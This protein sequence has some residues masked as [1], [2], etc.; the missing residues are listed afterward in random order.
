MRT[1]TTQ[2]ADARNFLNKIWNMARFVLMQLGDERPCLPETVTGLEDRYVLSRLAATVA[3][4]REHLET[5]NFNLAAEAIYDFTWHDVCDWYLEMAKVRLQNGSDDEAKGVLYHVLKE[6]VLLLHPFVPF[7]TEEIWQVLGEDPSSVSVAPFP[8]PRGGDR[9][10]AAEAAITALQE[11]VTGVRAI[12]SDLNVPQNAKVT[13]KL[14]SSSAPVINALRLDVE[15]LKALSGAAVWEFGSDLT[16]TPGSAR[17]VLSF[18]ELFV[19]LADLIDV[20]A[21]RARLEK[22]LGEVSVDLSQG[23]AKLANEQFLSRAPADVVEKERRKRDEFAQK[24]ERLEANLASL[25]A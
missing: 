1:P 6:I 2:L 19:P 20:P 3:T 5:Y 8:E 4:V 18:G 11:A 22:E 10:E 23:D 24:K 12:R 14:K 16:A 7:I 13:V 25:G 15:S 17:K 9:D 21:E